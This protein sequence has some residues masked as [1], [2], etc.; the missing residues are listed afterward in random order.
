MG[1]ANSLSQASVCQSGQRHHR[2]RMSASLAR[3]ITGI[4]CLPVWPETSPGSHVCQSGQRHHRDRMSA[5]LARDITGI[6]CL[7]VWPETSRG[8]HVIFEQESSFLVAQLVQG[9]FNLR[10]GNDLMHLALPVYMNICN[11]P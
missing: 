2:D 3:D 8:S 5:S 11:K 1:R 9:R 7:P 10:L 4:A 6:A